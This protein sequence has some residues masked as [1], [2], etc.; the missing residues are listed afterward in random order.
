MSDTARRRE[1]SHEAL[2]A[3][4]DSAVPISVEAALGGD[5]PAELVVS[6]LV[7]ASFCERL[8][9]HLR[10]PGAALDMFLLGML[11][12]PDVFLGRPLVEVLQLIAV[13]EAVRAALTRGEGRL[14]KLVALVAAY[15]RGV[16]EA[17]TAG[18]R[19]LDL[20]DGVVADAHRESIAWACAVLA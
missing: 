19:A 3:A 9:P 10:M 13:P 7:R 11:S 20:D 4:R 12:L 6:A 16:W 17:A 18:A 2:Q 8:A 14:G 1:N 5:R 15:E